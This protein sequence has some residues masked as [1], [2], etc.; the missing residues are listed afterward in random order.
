MVG[1]SNRRVAYQRPPGQAIDDVAAAFGEC[2]SLLEVNEVLHHVSG[3]VRY[4]LQAVRLRVAALPEGDGASLLEIQGF[5]DDIWGA[6]A[7]KGTEKLLRA[8]EQVEL[9]RR[10]AMPM[11]DETSEGWKPDPT[12][13]HPDRYFDGTAWTIWVRDKP[14]GTRSEDPAVMPEPRD[15]RSDEPSDGA[16]VGPTS[17]ADELRKLV[18]LRDEGVLT[19][20]EFAVQKARLLG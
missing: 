16:G 9:A 7:R 19:D 20:E 3:R 15:A 17:V 8:L 18:E 6:G 13:R 4:G 12:G 14:G 10:P 5:A 1:E 2:G 11:P